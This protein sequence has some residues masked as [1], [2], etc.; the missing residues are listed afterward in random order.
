MEAESVLRRRAFHE[1]GH[2]VVGFYRLSLVPLRSTVVP[3]D[4]GQTLG[5]ADWGYAESPQLAPFI[6]DVQGSTGRPSAE[7]R[8][9]RLGS[10][11]TRPSGSKTV[12]T[13]L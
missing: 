1:A 4:D 7:R 2:C 12:G 8:I 13:V 10:T 3:S 6:A 5:R 9:W 11:N